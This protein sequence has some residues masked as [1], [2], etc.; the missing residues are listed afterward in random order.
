M[1]LWNEKMLIGVP[2]IDEQHHNL[3]NALSELMTACAQDQ[4]EDVIHR[5]LLFIV[6]YTQ[7]HFRDEERI[8]AKYRYPLLEK[9]KK[10]HSGFILT[11]GE[12][13]NDYER[14][15][16]TNDLIANTSKILIDWVMEHIRTE[17]KK[18]GDYI[19]AISN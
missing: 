15:R 13:M 14:T 7:E 9:H 1:S 6:D 10:Q 12:L 8:Q 3:V 19:R 2:E 16:S 4:G 5:T 17:D 18:I 11:V